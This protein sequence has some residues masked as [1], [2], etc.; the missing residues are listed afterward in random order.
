MSDHGASVGAMFV[1]AARD[2][3]R[4]TFLRWCRGEERIT[5]TYAD[6]SLRIDALVARLDALGI[7]AGDHVVVHT[8]EIVP[9][10]L[11]SLACA[12]AGVVFTPIETSSLPAVLDLCA[13]TSARAVLTTP[14]RAG[15]YDA[16]P[17]LVEDGATLAA[18]D[19]A[20][21]LARLA[22][23][24]ARLDGTTT[25]MLQPTSGTTGGSKLVIRPHAAFVRV[26]RVL[27][28]GLERAGEPPERVLVV[29]ALT[30]GMGQ[31]LLSIAMSLAAELCVTTRID[32]DADIAEVRALDPTYLGLTPRVLRS[33]V[34]Q[35]G[36]VGRGERVFGPS[37]RY[38]LNGGAAP[39]AE[40]LAAVER[41]GVCVVNAYGAS[42]FSIVAMTRPGRWRP[43]LLGH[44]LP[45]VT[46]RVTEDGELLARTPVM[47]RGYHGA[48]ELT[49]AAFTDDGFYRTGDRV[50]LGPD[51]EF[52]YH[53]R[54]VDSFNL[55]DGSHV[56]PGPLEDAVTLLPWVE[57]VILLGDQRPSITGLLVP[58]PSL[59]DAAAR[60]APSFR[61]LI[62]RDLGRICSTLDPT[63]RIRRVAI[64]D[65]P[66]PEAI[67]QVVG[68]GKVRR[69]R[70]ATAELHSAI[71]AALY[72]PSPAPPDLLLVDIPGAAAERRTSSRHRQ[73]W[74]VRLHTGA[75]PL[76]AY[77]RDVSRSGAFVE[78]DDPAPDA[79]ALTLELLAPDGLCLRLDAEPVRHDPAGSAVRWTGPPDAL[80]ELVRRLPP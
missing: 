41:S 27:G 50:A 47:M 24:A 78:H 58:R 52:R 73:S 75:A 77:T 7:A 61:R 64:L 56:A 15:P 18:G 4:R 51:G 53:G 55:F 35:L 54:V 32:T 71:V 10:V 23:R 76:I 40:L 6:A 34:H 39:D 44:I 48:P 1:S 42:E 13:R 79:L 5:W 62:E 45:D 59:R 60:Q 29:A 19:L 36:G 21:S 37:A 72:G 11:F 30:H 28:F 22:E 63:A 33:F 12:C 70:A 9:S 46:L 2:Y 67:H 65:A 25:Y 49:R 66:F 26:A 31:Y 80:A 38:L 20:G 69:E 17:I 57:Q 16:C 3:P 43:D 8:A 14:D 68:H 74:L